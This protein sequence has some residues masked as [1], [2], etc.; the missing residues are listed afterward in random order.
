MIVWILLSLIV[1]GVLF[2]ALGFLTKG[3]ALRASVSAVLFVI[4][5][6]IALYI[7]SRVDAPPPGS[8]IITQDELARS[9]GI[10]SDHD[11]QSSDDLSGGGRQPD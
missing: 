2:F 11:S 7:M 3:I 5:C 6:G 1:S 4:L 10:K 9:A 8:R